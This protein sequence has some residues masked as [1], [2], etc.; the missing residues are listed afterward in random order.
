MAMVDAGNGEDD[1]GML[2][3]Q[4]PDSSFK[5]IFGASGEIL[6]SEESVVSEI[7][8]KGLRRAYSS[9]F[10]SSVSGTK[11]STWSWCW[12]PQTLP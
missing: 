5:V 7:L 9:S 3:L 12:L 2:R 1:L 11:Q 8:A 10:V 6:Q 4:V